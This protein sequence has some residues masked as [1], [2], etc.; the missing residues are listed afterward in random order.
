MRV[1][2]EF[3]KYCKGDKTMDDLLRAHIRS[4]LSTGVD[5]VQICEGFYDAPAHTIEDLRRRSRKRIG[6]VFEEFCKLYLQTDPNMANVWLLD[7]VPQEVLDH[8]HLS[9]RDMG[10]DLIA[11]DVDGHYHAIQAKFRRRPTSKKIG[12]PW[13]ELST[14]YALCAR[15]G[16]FRRHVVITTADY[17]RRAGR[18][19]TPQ[20]RTIAFGTLRNITSFRW[21]A[22]LRTTEEE[23]ERPPAP[24]PAAAFEEPSREELRARRL[25]HF[26]R[27]QNTAAPASAP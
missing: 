23:Q 21:M 4:S 11:Q 14:F 19:S 27:A 8:L 6:D 24:P 3:L 20:D 13:R 12:L 15:S 7:E 9:R 16:P 10:I 25:N 17:V 5:I 2:N 1:S 26:L 22:M 18:R